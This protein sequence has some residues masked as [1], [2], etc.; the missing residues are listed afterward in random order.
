[1]LRPDITQI[2]YRDGNT[3]KLAADGFKYVLFVQLYNAP[4]N[5]RPPPH[6]MP[7]DAGYVPIWSVVMEQRPLVVSMTSHVHDAPG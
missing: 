4:V 5:L 2:L 3:W 6:T 7:R 1:M